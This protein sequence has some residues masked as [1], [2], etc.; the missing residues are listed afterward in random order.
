MRVL[1]LATE[2]SGLGGLE[3]AQ[4]QACTQLRDRGHEIQLL[5]TEAGDLSQAWTQV[6]TRAVRVGGYALY[7]GDPLQTG[8]NVATVVHQ[9]RRLAPDVVY[10]HHHRHALAPALAGRPSLCH[11]HLPPPPQ[12]SRQDSFAL[13]RVN[14]FVAV[15]QFTAAQWTGRLGL[16]EDRIGIVHNGVDLSRFSPADAERRAEIRAALDLPIDRFL[17]LFAGRVGEPKGIDIA[18]EA[19]RTLDPDTF[20]LAI[21]GEPNAAD[22]SGSVQAGRD[23]LQDLQRRFDGLH[24]SW[25][26]RLKDTAPL[27]AAA[28][29]VVLPSRFPD[30]M[31]LLVLESMA[32]GTPI[33]ASDVGGIPEMLTGELADNLV[34]SGDPEALARRIAE[35]RDWRTERPGLAEA[36]RRVVEEEYTLE[37]MGDGVHAAVLRAAGQGA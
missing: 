14:A 3:R 19:M 2:L 15:S 36:G 9:I 32:S 7:R 1:T 18:L 26:G 16:A 10:F 34:P 25:L 17:V 27:M 35:L 28:D 29:L 31:P 11:M 24:A 6:A 22:F 12:E 21:A 13:G 37:R 30:P 20:H 5:F 33:V 23:Y 4:L 8:R